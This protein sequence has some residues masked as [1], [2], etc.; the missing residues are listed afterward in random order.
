MDLDTLARLVG[1]HHW[2]TD[3]LLA[4]AAGL[5]AERLDRPLGGS[6]STGR[7]LLTH[8]IGVERLWLERWNGG[9]PTQV[10]DLSGCDTPADFRAEWDDIKAGQQRFMT[11][12]SAAELTRPFTY[13]SLRGGTYTYPLGDVLQHVVNHGTYHRGQ[14]AHFLRQQ[15]ETPPST[16]YLLYLDEKR[17]R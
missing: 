8:V 16:D 5:P 12:L 1:Y 17:Q 13:T 10:P 7:G 4:A 3:R 11:A 6:F 15:G 9:T 2:A 14:I